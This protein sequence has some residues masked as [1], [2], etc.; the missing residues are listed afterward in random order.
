MLKKFDIFFILCYNCIWGDK[1]KRKILCFAIICFMVF[2]SY[3]T[4]AFESGRVNCDMLNVRVS[5]NTECEIVSQLPNGALFEIIYTD[6]GWYNIK[7]LNGVTGFVCADYVNKTNEEIPTGNTGTQIAATSYNYLGYSYVYG[8]AG[9]NAFDCSGFTSY[10]Y[11]QF[12]VT[13]P[14]TADYQAEVG[15]PVDKSNLTPG[16]LVFFSNR[17]NRSINH[18]GIYVGNGEFIH[19]STSTRGVVKD[20][21]YSNY[22][23]RSYV[24]ARRIV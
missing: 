2:T 20:S 1:M 21:L 7:M 19:A 13:I 15:M 12:G 22:Y 8:A 24:C 17:S 14:R 6:N 16:D 5:P 4:F 3:S 10:L 23:L 18:V 9:P 11:R